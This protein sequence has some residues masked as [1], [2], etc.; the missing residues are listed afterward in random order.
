MLSVVVP[1]VIGFLITVTM[2]LALRPVA[3]QLRLVDIPGGRKAHAGEVPIIGGLAIYLGLLA[4]VLATGVIGQRE[5][6]LMVAATVMLMV[7]VMDDRFD[8]PANVRILG[9]VAAVITL[10]LASGYRVESLGNLLGLGDM[11]LGS[12]S[13]IFTVV[14]AIALIN[15][16]NML[17]G[18]DGLA[19]G[20]ALMALGGLSF[21][22]YG[23]QLDSALVVSLALFGAIAAFLIFNLPARFNRPVLAFMGDAGSTLLG[24]TLAS[25]T[26]FAVQPR[27]VGLPPVV[28]LWLLP[29]PILELFTSTFRRIAKGLSPMRAD[30]GH[31]HYK[32]L[33][34]GFSVKAIF[35][36]YMATS[37][38]SGVVGLV[39]WRAGVSEPKLFYG[40]LVMSALWVLT[41]RD[42]KRVATYLPQ[43]LK[44]GEL[45][46]L[47]RRRR[48][49]STVPIV[50][51]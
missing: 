19:G 37:A 3:V 11:T 30:R 49:R 46:R 6:P 1:V 28:A 9:H 51:P 29:V 50:K 5:F 44:R 15:A 42:A 17:D 18:L 8:L 43:A 39:A 34:A 48:A 24:F 16:F 13:F 32:L 23:P 35:I 47:R 45:P 10:A 41:A 12:G 2:M 27:G 4:S 25:L 38:V 40:F 22:F 26:L 36:I 7:G 20:V 31:F 21:V 33:E 14:A